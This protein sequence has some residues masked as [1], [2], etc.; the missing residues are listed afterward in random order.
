MRHVIFSGS[1]RLPYGCAPTDVVTLLLLDIW[2]ILI[3]ITEHTLMWIPVYLPVSQMIDFFMVVLEGPKLGTF[4]RLLV[5][6]VKLFSRNLYVHQLQI[7]VTVFLYPQQLG[8][9]YI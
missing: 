6:T 5:H 9:S 4:G 2:N 8:V 7:R 1:V 3:L